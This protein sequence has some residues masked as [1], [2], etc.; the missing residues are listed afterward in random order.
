VAK[1]KLAFGFGAS[2]NIFYDG[3]RSLQGKLCAEIPTEEQ[4]R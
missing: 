1:R 4:K 2:F 3:W